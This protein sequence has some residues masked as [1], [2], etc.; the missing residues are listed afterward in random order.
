MLDVRIGVA[1][2][3]DADEKMVEIC[4]KHAGENK[5][6]SK[7]DFLMAMIMHVPPEVQDQAIAA[8]KAKR[9]EGKA[10][11]KEE[12]KKARKEQNERLKKLKS[13]SS[14]QID[15]LLAAQAA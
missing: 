7:G 9:E 10:Q 12:R 14:E 3:A 2:A 4:Q 1:I 13:L 8:L 6:L 15:A 5:P 11:H